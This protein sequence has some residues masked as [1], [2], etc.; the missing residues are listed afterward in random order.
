VAVRALCGHQLEMVARICSSQPGDILVVEQMM[1]ARPP[2][3]IGFQ[4]LMSNGIQFHNWP[5]PKPRN[6]PRGK[7]QGSRASPGDG[8]HEIGNTSV[9]R[10]HLGARSGQQ[11][12]RVVQPLSQHG[13]FLVVHGRL[14]QCRLP[15]FPRSILYKGRQRLPEPVERVRGGRR[16]RSKR[17]RNA[18]PMDAHRILRTTRRSGRFRPSHAGKKPLQIG[19]AVR[20]SVKKAS[21]SCST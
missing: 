7:P 18:I 5:L 15:S 16:F 17:L 20:G 2:I 1:D 13:T 8:F 11:S 4:P 21:D 6:L 19:R 10:S 12:Y 9:S 3:G 14:P